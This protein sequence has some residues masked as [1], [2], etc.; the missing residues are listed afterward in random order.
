MPGFR[1]VREA[2]LLANYDNSLNDEDFLLLYDINTSKNP[3]FPYWKYPSFDLDLL[4]ESECY[5]NFRFQKN[6]IYELKDLLGIPDDLICYNRTKVDGL[7]AL[8]ILLKRF[9]YPIRYGDMIPL[10]GRPVP[11]FSMISYEVLNHIY[12]NFNGLLTG[13]GH[14]WM[15]PASLENYAQVVHDKGGALDFCWGFVDG[16]VR[17]ICRPGRNQRILYNGHKRVHSIKFQSVVTPNGLIANLFGPVEGKRHD[18]AMLAQSG[19]LNQLQQHSHKPN[20]DILCIYGDPAYPLRPHLQAPFRA[21]GLTPD[22]TQ[23]NKSMSKVRVTVEW[24][25]KEIINYFKFMDFK[26]N[27]K[28]RLSAVGKMYI[29]CAFLQNCR[30]CLYGNQVSQFF[31]CDP[32]NIE[33]YLT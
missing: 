15:S 33:T 27:L 31:D 18:S 12:D 17:P 21:P 22:Q 23:F 26:K 9:A 10:F 7:E 4:D 14:P 19:L 2:L 25:F 28:V 24:L 6:D 32:P 8:C 20:G 16:T 30:T 5:A 3:D 11:E 29:V 13:F 1:E